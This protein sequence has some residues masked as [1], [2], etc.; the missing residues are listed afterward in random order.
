M[1]NGLD[2]RSRTGAQQEAARLKANRGQ[3]V[4]HLFKGSFTAAVFIDFLR[5]L[6]RQNDQP[7]FLIVDSQPVHRSARVKKWLEKN[8]ARLRL[9]F[10]P[11][12]CPE[13]NPDELV[14]Q[15][16]NANA[17]GRRRPATQAEMMADA[18]SYLRSTQRMRHIV[19]N[20]FNHPD[21]SYAAA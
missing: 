11:G 13:L 3:L 16:V 4:F 9:F 17:L 19:R 7:V 6:S 5:R 8:S 2:F 20:Y 21:V 1:N 10:L 12:Y 18:R 14:N 15:D